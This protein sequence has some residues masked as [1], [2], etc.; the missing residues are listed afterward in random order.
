MVTIYENAAE[1]A[2]IDIR[3][4]TLAA[5]QLQRAGKRLGKLGVYLF[6]G[7]GSLSLRYDDAYKGPDGMIHNLIIGHISGVC[8]DGGDGGTNYYGDEFMRGE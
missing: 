8:V 3:E 7:S 4:L 6:G 2:G 5:R 1:K